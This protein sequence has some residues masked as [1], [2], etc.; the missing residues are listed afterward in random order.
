M[1]TAPTIRSLASTLRC[2]PE[3]QP[4]GGCHGRRRTALGRAKGLTIIELML[5]VAILGIFAAIALPAY[6][7][8]RERIRVFQAVNDIGAISTLIYKFAHDDGAFPATLVEVGAN[9][10]RDPWGNPYQYVNHEDRRSR[11][12]WR[13]DKNIVPINNDFDVFSM[14][15]DGRSVPPL[16]AKHSRD[17][18]VRANDGRFIGLASDYD[19]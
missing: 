11:G 14:G 18:I 17:D 3:A 19:P 16:T 8:Y 9:A 4:T 15:E 12:Q 1:P 6:E 5:I 13:K 10:M 7:R 2:S